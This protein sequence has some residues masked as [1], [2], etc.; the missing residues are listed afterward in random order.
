M[1]QYSGAKIHKIEDDFPNSFSLPFGHFRWNSLLFGRVP[2]E[3]T[4]TSSGVLRIH[5]YLIVSLGFHYYLVRYPQN[6]L[7]FGIVSAFGLR[8]RSPPHSLF[9]L[10]SPPISVYTCIF[11]DA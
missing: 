10:P 11:D 8:Y 9:L 7:L 5:Y 2:S 1:P 6:S 3:F 4:T